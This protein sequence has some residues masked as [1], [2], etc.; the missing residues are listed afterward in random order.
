MATFNFIV[1]INFN[2][3]NESLNDG[4]LDRLQFFF[5]II[6]NVAIHILNIFFVNSGQCDFGEIIFLLEL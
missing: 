4:H 3:F 6:S 2:L 5:V 1:W